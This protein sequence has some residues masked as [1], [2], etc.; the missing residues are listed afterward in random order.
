MRIG[1]DMDNTICETGK[2]LI[3]KIYEWDK[4][5]DRITKKCKNY[6]NVYQ[7][8]GYDL[9]EKEKFDNIYVPIMHKEVSMIKD[10]NKVINK[11]KDNG[12]EIYIITYRGKFQYNNYLEVT[13]RW[14]ENHN[15]S[16]DKIITERFNKGEVCKEFKID[17]LIDDEPV[18]LKQAKNSGTNTILFNSLFNGYCNEY[19]RANSWEDVYNI[20][21]VNN[22]VK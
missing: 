2:Y 22:Q 6:K 8:F 15:I 7:M 14:L 17:F 3:D 13:T 16:Y 9:D 5:N 20:I 1:I 19:K 11:L 12:I 21:N 4:F 18:H 10:A